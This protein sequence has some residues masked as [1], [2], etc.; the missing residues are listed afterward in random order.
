MADSAQEKSEQPTGKRLEDSRSK[1]E[2]AKSMEINS[3]ILLFLATA[4]IYVMKDSIG[5]SIYTLT[6]TVFR[7]VTTFE[8]NRDLLDAYAMQGLYFFASVVGPIFAVLVVASVIA[9]Y[10]QVGFRITIKALKPKLSKLNAFKNFKSMFLSSRAFVELAKT[11]LKLAIISLLLYWMLADFI[12]MAL[13]TINYSVAE[14][15]STMVENVF[16]LLWKVFMVFGVL[17]F[18]DF[19]YQRKKHIKDLKMTKQEVKDENK[20][21]EGDPLIKGKI[22]G[23]QFEMARRRMMQDVPNA[24]VVITNPTHVAVALR[25]EMGAEGAPVVVAKGLDAVAQRIKEI[26]KEHNIPMYEDVQLARALFKECEIGE[27]IPQRMF[28][29]VA[30]I[31][32]FIFRK[33]NEKKRKSIV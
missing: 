23:K 3:F 21:I 25:Y 10:G 28:K 29:A 31:L 7:D 18:A 20:Q 33:K 12:L 30:Q 2:V 13:E 5:Q 22:R 26:A 11:V 16:T 19:W 15:V 27:Q 32:A 17:A 1:G 14:I 9:G 6:E 8:I 24:S 4:S